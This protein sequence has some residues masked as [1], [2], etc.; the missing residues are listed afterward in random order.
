MIG[1]VTNWLAVISEWFAM[2]VLKVAR[3]FM[4]HEA[5][6]RVYGT[7]LLI[8]VFVGI[9]PLYSGVHIAPTLYRT[10]LEMLPVNRKRRK[11]INGVVGSFGGKLNV[12]LERLELKLQ[13]VGFY[14]RIMRRRFDKES[15][16]IFLKNGHFAYLWIFIL[17]FIWIPVISSIIAA[18]T[19]VYDKSHEPEKRFWGTIP[20]IVFLAVASRFT[21]T[22]GI[23]YVLGPHL[24][25]VS[26]FLR[27]V[28][29]PVLVYLIS[30]YISVIMLVIQDRLR[31]II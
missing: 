14:Q 22:A 12:L 19:F 29:V 8:T 27:E 3:S 18:G 9:V 16:L 20:I 15:I 24:G 31:I 2:P 25:T 13:R 28:F 4:A 26:L 5:M 21:A 23:C 1:I 6:G 7:S 10:L 11:E 30:A 17:N